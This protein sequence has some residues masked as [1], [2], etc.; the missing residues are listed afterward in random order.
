VRPW[1][2][3]GFKNFG[4]Y[5]EQKTLVHPLCVLPGVQKTIAQRL[6]HEAA[7]KP[8]VP[9]L[10]GKLAVGKHDGD[11]NLLCI[12]RRQAEFRKQPDQVY[13]H[14]SF[15]LSVNSLPER[16]I[17]RRRGAPVNAPPRTVTTSR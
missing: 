6:W 8:L 12:A 16:S 15:T 7:S 14:L 3:A 10:T 9:L 17:R 5:L 11:R 2:G 13:L 4:I 1:A